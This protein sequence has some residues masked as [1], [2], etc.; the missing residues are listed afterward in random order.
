MTAK[1]KWN[2]VY[3][4]FTSQALFQ[5]ASILVIT[6]SGVVGLQMAPDKNLATLPLAMITVGTAGMMIPA[7][8]IIKKLG[9][10]NAFMIGTLIGVL[11]GLVSWYGIVQNSFWLFSV[12][13]M[14][15]GAYQ[16][17][18]QYYRFAAADA[19]PDNAK[20]KAISFVIAGGVV[21][22]FAGPNLAR[23]TQHLG[24]VPY[25]YSYFSI[26]LLSVVALG[27]VSFL[28][29]QK[30]SAIQTNEVVTKGRPIK[31]IIKNKDTILAILA[32]ATAFAVMGMSMTVTPIAMHS[33]GHS[34]DSSATVIQ[35]HVLGMFL[36]SFFTGML[37]QKFGVYRIIISGLA[38][39]FLYIII[40]LM[41]TGFAHFVSALFVVGL[42]WNFLF[43]GGSS[44]LTKVYRPEEK[45][46]TQAFHDFTVFAVISIASFF[47][48]S[49]FNY[50]GWNGVNI[51]MIPMLI[52]TLIV[53]IRIVM[54][55]KNVVG[56]Q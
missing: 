18:S 45:E 47:A 24:A 5:T 48:G 32:S 41:G 30:A 22:A 25:A 35:W 51:V 20:S 29:L 34:S 44:L 19:V 28:K 42:G 46:K 56:K 50:W 11:S 54:S 33:V 7:S 23:F 3:L 26:I 49:L 36:P 12:G 13:N 39:L 43:I 31:E 8:L 27:V 14:L 53:V 37:I 55:Q 1:I 10:R 40:A 15:I 17:F 6:L 21:A 16:G 52:I 38:I 2:N 9:Q 4:L